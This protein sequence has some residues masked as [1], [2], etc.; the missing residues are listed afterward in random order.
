MN[1]LR[2]IVVKSFRIARGEWEFVAVIAVWLFLSFMVLDA[3]LKPSGQGV[4]LSIFFGVFFILE[5]FLTVS[6]YAGLN[7]SVSGRPW[8]VRTLLSRGWYFLPRILLYKVAVAC[9]VLVIAAMLLA[10]P[11]FFAEMPL[12]AAGIFVT[13]LLAWLSFPCGYLLFSLY[14]PLIILTDDKE[15]LPAVVVS[16]RLGR[17]YL[18]ELVVFGVMLGLPWAVVNFVPLLYNVPVRFAV[19]ERVLKSV[20]LALLEVFTIKTFLLFYHEYGRGHHEGTV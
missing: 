4:L 5:N 14:T 8:L 11:A 18:P 12:V 19:P 7:E 9:F 3:I 13:L 2:L 15:L 6:V 1:P 20:I 16:F 17:K 10:L